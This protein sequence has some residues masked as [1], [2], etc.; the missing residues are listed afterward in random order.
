MF[1]YFTSF[2]SA[3]AKVPQPRR[4]AKYLL[5]GSTVGYVYL[6]RH[7]LLDR[8]S[9]AGEATLRVSRT[10]LVALAILADYKWTLRASGHLP[11]DLYD[12]ARR[13]CHRRGADRLR[14]LLIANKGLY[15]KFGQHIASLDYV[16]P[17]EYCTQMRMFYRMAPQSSTSEVERVIKE[18]ALRERG[19][20]LVN[21]E[22]IF[23]EWDSV[24]LG[25]ASLAQ[26][27]RARLRSTGEAV[28]VKVQHPSVQRHAQLD[29]ATVGVLVRTLKRV[30][31][32]EISFD[33]LVEEMQAML[34]REMDFVQEGRNA[35][36][37]RGLLLAGSKLLAPHEI[38]I[39]RVHWPWTSKRVLVMQLVDPTT[40]A[41]VTDDAFRRLHGIDGYR[42]AD[43]VARLHAAM[44]F[45]VGFVHCDLHPGN[46]FLTVAPS[47]GDALPLPWYRRLLARWSL[48]GSKPWQVILL[49]HGLYQ[50]L[51]PD[52]RVNY[53]RLWSAVMEGREA[54]IRE[55]VRPLGG[56]DAYKLFAC[57]LTK[58]TWASLVSDTG[59]VASPPGPPQGGEDAPPSAIFSP[60]ASNMSQLWSAQGP[61]AEESAL[62]RAKAAYFLTDLSQLLA[63]V[64]RELLL[65]LKTNDLLR[66]IERRLLLSDAAHGG[67]HWRGGL[68]P[69]LLTMARVC[70]DVTGEDDLRRASRE[71]HFPGYLIKSVRAWLSWVARKLTLELFCLVHS[72]ISFN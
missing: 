59:S 35:D 34:P 57:I 22:D 40:S 46:L 8:V 9:R 24:P 43:T 21:L 50:A 68:P 38:A 7:P 11:P 42:V 64:P 14:R 67:G 3:F 26:V 25:T 39:P 30:F 13:A 45:E 20:L 16:L 60:L 12:E 47:G 2:R 32:A 36:R 19:Q 37:L 52:F 62:I 48:A 15:I 17:D 23:E 51:E 63:R 6:H 5:V 71:T 31:P 65:L 1:N 54:A 55:A 29:I 58:R 49:D 4:L 66:N 61:S 70:I 69:S 18:D 56:G 10:C 28:A 44:V 41:P 53:A 33:W 72:M 27:H